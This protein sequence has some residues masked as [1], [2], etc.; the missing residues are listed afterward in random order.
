MIKRFHIMFFLCPH[1]IICIIGLYHFF[2]IDKFN[3]CLLIFFFH[4]NIFCQT[5]FFSNPLALV[6]VAH[7]LVGPFVLLNFQ[8]TFRFLRVRSWHLRSSPKSPHT[9]IFKIAKHLRASRRNIIGNMSFYNHYKWT[10]LM[11]PKR[12]Q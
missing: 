1:D 8:L 9:I 12:A 11:R 5:S 4:H 6:L 2:L 10:S 3:I 7:V